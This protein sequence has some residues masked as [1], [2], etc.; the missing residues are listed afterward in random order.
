MVNVRPSNAKLVDRAKRIIAA[1]TPC[2]VATAGEL[3][4]SGGSVKV[5]I[6][7]GRLGV[8]IEVAEEL[9]RKERGIL[10]RVLGS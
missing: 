6:V 1:A 4:A 3:L 10:R 9:L 5:A 7:M 8:G 2:D